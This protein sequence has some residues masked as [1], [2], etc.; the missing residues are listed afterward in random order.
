M[1][2]PP[3]QMGCSIVSNPVIA[4]CSG[5]V[6]WGPRQHIGLFFLDLIRARFYWPKMVVNVKRKVR[7]FGRC[8]RRKA[9]PEKA[10]PLVNIRT[11]R[12]FELLCMDY[13]SLKADKSGTKDLQLPSQHLIR[14]PIQLL[15]VCGKILWYTMV[16]QRNCIVTRVQNLSPA[17]SRNSI[18]WLVSKVL[19]TPYQPRGNPVERF[20]R[21][22]LD[23]LGT[24]QKQDESR[25]HDHVR[26]MFHAYNSTRNLVTAFTPYELM[27]GC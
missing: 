4:S 12:P 15:S 13:L 20:N 11:S 14:R 1:D 2:Y 16:S 18:R 5:D 24:L 6:E 17:Q 23:M 9:R 21:T 3:D 8:V 19:T 27:F 7:T 22:L 25:W 10:A 26:P